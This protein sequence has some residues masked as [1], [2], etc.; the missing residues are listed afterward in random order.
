MITSNETNE[1]AKALA[2]AQAELKP[3]LRDKTAEVKSEK[4]NYKFDYADLASVIEACRSALTKHGIAVVQGVEVDGGNVKV[5]TRLIHSSGQWLSST[6]AMKATGDRPQ[7]VGSAITYA[8]R[9]SLSAMVG[10][11]SEE[12]DDANA[13]Q[14]NH[15]EIGGRTSPKPPDTNGSA[16]Q[17]QAA[18]DSMKRKA[19]LL[20]QM[21]ER[22]PGRVRVELAHLLKR[23]FPDKEEI[24]LS[25]NELNILEASLT[26]AQAVNNSE[27]AAAGH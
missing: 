17:N 23:T 20:R 24:R 7:V 15:G 19:G 4:G 25:N 22:Y 1:V 11:A 5:E 6:L 12:D 16:K 13:A 26:L 3:V 18:I 9:Y 2:A 10:L 27:Q 14:G 21:E 8:R